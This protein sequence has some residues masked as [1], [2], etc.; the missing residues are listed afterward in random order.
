M[1]H[2]TVGLD[3]AR[4]GLGGVQLDALFEAVPLAIAGYVIVRRR[5]SRYVV[6]FTNVDLLANLVPRTP[7]WRRHV[8]PG[9]YVAAMAALVTEAVRP[10][11]TG[12]ATGINTVMRTVGGVMGAQIGAAIL[13]ADT[14]AGTEVPAESAYVSA[15]VLSAVAAGFAAVIAVF[16]TPTRIRRRRVAVAVGAADAR[17]R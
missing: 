16:V 15:F 9:L 3:F 14:L 2:P 1:T 4:I 6:R 5:R 10:T 12:V 8:P 11:E 7:A 17:V 13:S